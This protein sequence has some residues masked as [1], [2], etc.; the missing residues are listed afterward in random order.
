MMNRGIRL[1]SSGFVL[2]V[3]VALAGWS[4]V[5]DSD[6]PCGAGQARG[7]D[8]YCVCAGNARLEPDTHQC[9]ACGAN[10]V[11]GPKG[12]CDC[13]AG[14]ARP[15][16]GQPCAARE[17]G[18]EDACDTASKPCSVARFDHCQP[19]AGTAG[20]CT[21]AGCKATAECPAGFTCRA[22]A[23]PPYCARPPVGQGKA[24]TANADCAGSEATLCDTL[25]THTCLVEGC[26]VK[27]ASACSSGFLCC[28]LSSFG[29]AKTVC[30][31]LAKCP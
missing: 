19:T 18:L 27:D 7:P 12:A 23:A 9:V 22:S 10:E 8:G 16:P 11:V 13:A 2:V 4:C 14:Y 5:Y 3:A 30:A 25:Y 31:P 1:R 21:S 15:A 24:C 28:D 26:D 17:P 6:R 20:Y 29:L